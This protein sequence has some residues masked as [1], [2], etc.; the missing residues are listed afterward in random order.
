MSWLTT[1]P[2]KKSITNLLASRIS[3]LLSLPLILG[4]IG[5]GGD[6]PVTTDE[7][8]EKTPASEV[9]STDITDGNLDEGLA[10][11]PVEPDPEESEP[12]EVPDPNGVFLPMYDEKDGKMEMVKLNDHPV[13]SNGEGYFLWTNGS[14]W[15]ITTKI[16]SGRTVA[17][18]G[19]NLPKWRGQKHLCRNGL[20][21][22][23]S[24]RRSGRV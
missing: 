4:T 9:D 24:F 20:R 16:G 10:P 15:N 2:S 23:R 12:L 13:Y 21:P 11:D 19:E 22:H 14:L 8:A 17:S 5:C 18:G 1:Y 7:S 3:F 6:D